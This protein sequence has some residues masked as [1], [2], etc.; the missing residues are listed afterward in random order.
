MIILNDLRFSIRMNE[1]CNQDK[2]KA[3]LVIKKMPG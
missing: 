1:Q 2:A 3:L